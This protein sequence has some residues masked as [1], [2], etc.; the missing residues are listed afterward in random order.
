MVRLELKTACGCTRVVM[1]LGDVPPQMYVVPYP[2]PIRMYEQLP[3]FDT[4]FLTRTF[5]YVRRVLD[6]E[7]RWMYEY[8]E[9]VQ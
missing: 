6:G 7:G 4:P 8:Q 9:V 1:V 5:A 2:R 3:W